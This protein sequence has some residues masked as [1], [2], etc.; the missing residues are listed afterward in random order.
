MTNKNYF[1]NCNHIEIC[2]PYVNQLTISRRYSVTEHGHST[3]SCVL[4]YRL[5]LLSMYPLIIALATREGNSCY[6]LWNIIWKL[7]CAT[8]LTHK[9][10]RGILNVVPTVAIHLKSTDPQDWTS[11]M[12]AWIQTLLANSSVCNFRKHWRQ[13]RKDHVKNMQYVCF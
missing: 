5:L 8:A 9:K 7:W 11:Q 1:I 6:I 13:M 4:S 2:F 3:S 12:S 10:N